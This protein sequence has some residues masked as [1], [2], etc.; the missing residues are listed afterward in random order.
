M[1]LKS[2]NIR[3]ST[4]DW[5]AGLAKAEATGSVLAEHFRTWLRSWVSGEDPPGEPVDGPVTVDG[6]QTAHLPFPSSG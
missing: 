4:E 3:F 2:H 5:D 1:A 6:P